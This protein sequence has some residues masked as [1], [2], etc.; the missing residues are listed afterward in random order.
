MVPIFLKNSYLAAL[1]NP[2]A[3][4]APVTAHDG[5]RAFYRL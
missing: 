1:L 5:P 4:E 3:P 2:L